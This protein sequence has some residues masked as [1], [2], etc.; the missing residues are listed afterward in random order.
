MTTSRSAEATPK[1]TRPE[2]TEPAVQDFIKKFEKKWKD[3][4]DCRKGYVVQVCK[5]YKKPKTPTTPAAP[6]QP[7]Q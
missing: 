1:S 3:R 5:N 4:T 7:Q 2:S 6:Q